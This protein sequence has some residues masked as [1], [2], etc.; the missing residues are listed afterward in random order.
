MINVL[1]IYN[2]K[3]KLERETNHDGRE[4]RTNGKEN[5]SKKSKSL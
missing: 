5:I 3:W 1:Y 2:I 4:T